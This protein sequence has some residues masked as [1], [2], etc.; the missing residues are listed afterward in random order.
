M[1]NPKPS[2][3]HAPTRPAG[4]DSTASHFDEDALHVPRGVSRRTFYFLIGLVILLMLIWLVPGAISSTFSGSRNPVAVR[5]R[6]PGGAEVEWKGMEVLN[7]HRA[8]QDGLAMDPILGMQLGI[9]M[10]KPE[11]SSLTRLMVLD[12]FAR[13]AGVEVTDADLAAH[14][15]QRFSTFGR[16]QEDFRNEVRARGFDQVSV[17]EAI[18]R[19]VR[20]LR[21][22]QLVGFAGALP[23]PAKIEE[24]WHRDNEEFAFD[25]ATLE[26]ASLKEAARAELPDDAKLETWFGKLPEGE[27]AEFKSAERRKA[28]LALFRDSETTPASELLAAYPES[29]PEG[30]AATAPDELANQYYNR[31]YAT[32]FAKDPTEAATQE[33]FPG[34]FTFEE[35][36]EACLAEAPVFFAL[37]RWI[38]DLNTRRTNGETLDFAAEAGKYGLELRSEPEARTRA[39]YALDEGS[40]EGQSELADAVFSTAPDGSVHAVPVATKQGLEVVRV[41]ERIEPE[42]PAFAAMRDR[43]AEKWLGPKAEELA[44]A[45]LKTLREGFERFEPAKEDQ[46]LPQRKKPVHLRATSEAFRSAVEAA[47][48]TVKAR[49]YL[50]KASAR[51]KLPEDPEQRVLFNQANAF[52]LYTLEA[53]EVAEPGLAADKQKAFLVRLAGRREVPLANMSPAQYE[54]YK[55]SARQAAITELGQG[56]D[57]D[58]LRENHGLWLLEDEQAAAAAAKKGS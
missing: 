52:G 15:R 3:A 17:E 19:G 18:R 8:L 31:A 39:E 50:N 23:A 43:V 58:F 13:E 35:V 27:Q 12:H 42:M 33:G 56:L 25:Y 51:D 38:D 26:V 5:F 29:I 9:D 55:Q 44:L 47:G 46:P 1:S 14:L 7:G 36:K 6:T 41:N 40:S 57:L 34:F 49:D 22:Q 2:T 20:V 45:R 53:D 21:F 54:S 24:L 10:Q 4:K 48:L 37:Q 30:G 32:R 28:E 11:P 16:T